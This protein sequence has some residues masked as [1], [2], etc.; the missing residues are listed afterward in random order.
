MIAL[1][2]GYTVKHTFSLLASLPP[3]QP[4]ITDMYKDIQSRLLTCT[5]MYS[6]DL[7]TC[8]KIYSQAKKVTTGGHPVHASAITCNLGE[9]QASKLTI[10]QTT[11]WNKTQGSR[12]N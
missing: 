4:K 12:L 10:L 3:P 1:Y 7:L 11:Y 5:K 6:Q 8:T 9:N 2:P